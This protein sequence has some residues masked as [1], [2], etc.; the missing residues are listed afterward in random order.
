[1]TE[2]SGIEE[3]AV[4]LNEELRDAA[5]VSARDAAR[6]AAWDSAWDACVAERDAWIAAAWNAAGDKQNR[7]LG[8]AI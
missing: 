4:E 2:I 7:R 6:A 1:M 3:K 8:E 5:W